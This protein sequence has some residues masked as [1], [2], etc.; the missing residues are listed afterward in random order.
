LQLRG[1]LEFATHSPDQLEL[2]VFLTW[3]LLF[4]SAGSREGRS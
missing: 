4:P 3:R 2:L 1:A